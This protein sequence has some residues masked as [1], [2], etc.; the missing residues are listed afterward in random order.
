MKYKLAHSELELMD[1]FWASNKEKCKWDILDYFGNQ[2]KSGSAISFLLSKLT[3]KGFL[4]PRREG[5]NFFY[6][7]AISKLEYERS[8]INE[9]LNIT[10]GQS[11]EM[12]LANFCG[13]KSVAEK[14]IDKIR[15]WLD[16]LEQKLDDD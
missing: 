5:R 16:D 11:L 2:G 12:I 13:K 1:F 10:Y 4:V 14:D 9:S 7:P 8:I 3:K 15:K 6:T